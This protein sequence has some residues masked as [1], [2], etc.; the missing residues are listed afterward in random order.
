MVLSKRRWR[1]CNKNQYCH[2]CI[3]PIAIVLMAIVITPTILQSTIAT[4][5]T[6]LPPANITHD[7]SN[8]EYNNSLTLVP[9]NQSSVLDKTNVTLRGLF[10]DLANPGRWDQ[11][12]QPALD[13][14]NRRHPDMNIQ[15][16]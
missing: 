8:S 15:I 3:T 16:E 9:S 4:S 10:T 7:D 5:A 12:L 6:N 1:Q 11:L 14:L 13:E 2:H